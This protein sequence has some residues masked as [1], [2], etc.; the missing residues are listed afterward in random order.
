MSGLGHTSVSG[1]LPITPSSTRAGL[2]QAR[3]RTPS[4]PELYSSLNLSYQSRCVI[5]SHRI[6]GHFFLHWGKIKWKRKAEYGQERLFVALFVLRKRSDDM[7]CQS[8]QSDDDQIF[9]P[10]VSS[11]PCRSG[12]MDHQ[13]EMW[14]TDGVTRLPRS[15]YYELKFDD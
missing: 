1:C 10:S 15:P 3:V 8:M 12:A 13:S 6:L 7:Q 14:Q 4:T 2:H 5:R 11:I 9:H